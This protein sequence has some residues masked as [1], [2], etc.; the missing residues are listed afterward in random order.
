M[1]SHFVVLRCVWKS[2]ARSMFLFCALFE[3]KLLESRH[4]TY[5]DLKKK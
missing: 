4:A 5:G 1:Q 2:E 3:L